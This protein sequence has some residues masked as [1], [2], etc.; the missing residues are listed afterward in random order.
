MTDPSSPEA[1]AA[2]VAAEQIVAKLAEMSTEAQE[3]L[4]CD[5]SPP[6]GTC[7]Q[8]CAVALERYSALDDAAQT[9]E[10]ILN[11]EFDNDR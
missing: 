6:W 3:D 7:G 8:Q 5:G 10:R 4:C 9:A 2:L 11:G 1:S